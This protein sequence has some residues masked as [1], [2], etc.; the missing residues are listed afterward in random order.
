VHPQNPIDL[1]EGIFLEQAIQILTINCAKT[2][3]RSEITGSIEVGKSADFVILS[4]NLFEIAPVKISETDVL[5]TVFEGETVIHTP[6]CHR[7][8][9]VAIL[10]S[11]PFKALMLLVNGSRLQNND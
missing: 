9:S 5:L 11:L 6:M 2:L 1:R 7:E 8:R 10:I 3:G 4:Q